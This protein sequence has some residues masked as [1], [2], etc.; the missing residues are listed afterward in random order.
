MPLDVLPKHLKQNFYHFFVQLRL[1]LK[2]FFLLFS[3]KLTTNKN[4]SPMRKLL[5]PLK[6]FVRSS[7]DVR[8]SLAGRKKLTDLI[9]I[10]LFEKEYPERIVTIWKEYYK[11][12]MEV[13]ADA[14][15][16]SVF[17]VFIQRLRLNPHFVLPVH[18][19]LGYLNVYVQFQENGILFTP[20]KEFKMHGERAQPTLCVSYYTELEQSKELVL[21]RGEVDVKVIDKVEAIILMRM[22]YSFYIQNDLFERFVE[23]FNHR[24]NEFNY[25]K[26]IE[27]IEH[28]K[29]KKIIKVPKKKQEIQ[30]ERYG[31]F[32]LRTNIKKTKKVLEQ[33]KLE[34]KMQ[35]EKKN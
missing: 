23:V 7:S 34:E 2:S 32:K 19:K 10:E 9:H 17:Q 33:M 28:S 16:S 35:N 11:G 27:E 15:K 6:N 1:L 29:P 13:Y 21:L 20:L 26:F 3:S 8:V 12:K 22:L 25:Q 5:Y 24:P 14:M 4:N 18:K 31:E 30:E